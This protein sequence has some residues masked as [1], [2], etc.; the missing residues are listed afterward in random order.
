MN[1]KKPFYKKGVTFGCGQCM[2]CR[3]DRSR[4]TTSRILLE[5]RLHDDNTFVT[6]TYSEEYLP[7]GGTLIKKDLQG[8][9]KRLRSRLA[10]RRIRHLGV[11]EYGDQTGR[12]HYHIC[13]FGLSMF[14]EALVQSCWPFGHIKMDELNDGT[15]GY[16]SQYVVKKWTNKEDLYVA[17]LLK[18][19]EP[20]FCIRSLKP[21]IGAGAAP[22]IASALREHSCTIPGVLRWEGKKRPFGRYIKTKI[23]QEFWNEEEIKAFEKDVWLREMYEENVRT[24]EKAERLGKTPEQLRFEERRQRFLNA[25]ARHKIFKSRRTL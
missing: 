24:K 23:R 15:A 25:T 19:R 3:I 2:S 10:P 18:G 7:P 6:L 8:F 5:S 1:C 17:A 11:G 21:G 14:E 4:L 9:V 20:E 12:P 13:I 22:I 16:I